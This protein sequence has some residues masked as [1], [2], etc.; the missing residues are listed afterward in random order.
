[1]RKVRFIAFY[2]S[3]HRNQ[4]E[5][6]DRS[7]YSHYFVCHRVSRRRTGNGL[8][9]DVFPKWFALPLQDDGCAS[10]LVKLPHV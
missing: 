1:M 3:I 4:S 7:L 5:R 10:S 2:I 6:I 9:R 8:F